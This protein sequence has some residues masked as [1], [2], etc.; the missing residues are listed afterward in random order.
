MDGCGSGFG[1][2][3]SAI[4]KS[5]V[6]RLFAFDRAVKFIV[7]TTAMEMFCVA[8]CL[9]GCAATEGDARTS[10]YVRINCS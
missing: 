8:L 10:P 3:S 5:V 4:E 6:A 2:G 9:I 1:F 7:V